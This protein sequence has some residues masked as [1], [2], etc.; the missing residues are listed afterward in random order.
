MLYSSKN[1]V[2]YTSSSSWLIK[3]FLLSKRHKRLKNYH[4]IQWLGTPLMISFVTCTYQIL[5]PI[6]LIKST[7]KYTVCVQYANPVKLPPEVGIAVY[8][9]AKTLFSLLTADQLF[10]YLFL[11]LFTSAIRSRRV[12]KTEPWCNLVCTRISL[13][14][15]PLTINLRSTSLCVECRNKVNH[16]RTPSSLFDAA[17]FLSLRQ[18]KIDTGISMSWYETKLL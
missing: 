5:K 6:I 1:T 14:M 3:K 8:T 13:L 4:L 9:S 12:F 2:N 18:V 11:I 17:F 10:W 15:E 7:K 16:W